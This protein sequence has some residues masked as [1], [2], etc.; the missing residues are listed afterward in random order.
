MRQRAY[1][2]VVLVAA[3]LSACAVC[4]AQ[5]TAIAPAATVARPSAQRLALTLTEALARAEASP[6]LVIA[7]AARRVGESGL[8]VAGAPAAPALNASTHSITARLGLSLAIPIRYAGQ[9]GSAL[10]IAR[11]ERDAA[12]AETAAAVDRAREQVTAAWFR[13][14]ANQELETLASARVARVDRTASA[15]KALFE[16]GRVPRVDLVKAQAEAATV[17]AEVFFAAAERRA[18]S[19]QLAFL[20]GAP[21]LGEL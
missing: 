13:L 6:D 17:Q 11:A 18:A 12:A 7:R 15:V 8:A 16:A 4:A 5:S 21:V 1:R 14:A 20:I 9:R 3:S 10:E 2:V 19:A